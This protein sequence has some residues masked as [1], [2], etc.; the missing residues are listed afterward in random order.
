MQ[1]C[2]CSCWYLLQGHSCQL[3]RLACRYDFEARTLPVCRPPPFIGVQGAVQR[4]LQAPLAALRAP[5]TGKNRVA[6]AF[7]CLSLGAAAVGLA[8]VLPVRACSWQLPVTTAFTESL[9]QGWG[10][11]LS[12]ARLSTN[13]AVSRFLSRV[14]AL[15]LCQAAVSLAVIQVSCAAH[16]RWG[17]SCSLM[18]L[19]VPGCTQSRE[20]HSQHIPRAA[21][22]MR[23]IIPPGI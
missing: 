2:S 8:L 11:H 1:P 3:Q 23:S 13:D 22:R 17:T 16:C 5:T 21:A 7:G 14:I 9:L 6:T 12:V 4:C 18:I 15:G 20:A 19:H 10:Q